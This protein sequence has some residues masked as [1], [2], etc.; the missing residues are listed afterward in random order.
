VE[1]KLSKSWKGY[2]LPHDNLKNK[3]V[4]LY[5]FHEHILPSCPDCHGQVTLRPDLE[6]RRIQQIELKEVPLLR[7]EHRS[8][9]VWCPGCEKIHYMPFPDEVVKAGLFKERMTALVAYM[10]Y[11]CHASFS[12]IRKFVRDVLGE[13]VSRGYLRK[14]LAKVTSSLNDP[15]EDVLFLEN[16]INLWFKEILE[17]EDWNKFIKTFARE[18]RK[19]IE[20]LYKR[21]S[22]IKVKKN[23]I[24]LAL[25]DTKLD[26][27]NP[28]EWTE[29][30]L[31][32]FA[33]KLREASK[34]ILIVANKIDKE[35]SRKNLQNLVQK[36]SDP[37]IPC[38][39]LAEYMLRKYDEE[40]KLNYTPG[41]NNFKILNQEKL[42]SKELDILQNIKLK[43]LDLYHE[44]GVQKALN[45]A[46][47]DISNQICVF[48]VSD[49]NNYTDNNNNVLPDAILVEKGTLLREFVREKIHTDLADHFM[50][51]IDAIT[52][53]RL[54]ENYE[55]QHNDVIKIV[56]SK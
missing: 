50:F 56:T 1:L 43:I 12:T 19:F 36:Y 54:G 21:L 2:L 25:N 46:V 5:K 26:G 42:N 29:D 55:L 6:P 32:N 38:S 40:K 35:I 52:K 39:S 4:N 48:P 30:D 24:I 34:P 22:G 37:I 33:K 17:R 11:V 18:K 7:E 41:S 49:V 51:G 14:V 45:F 15:Y 3:S 13:E 20:E 8:Y 9:A 16:E 23:Q 53:K 31:F 27:K 44:T 10:K 28:S 47:F